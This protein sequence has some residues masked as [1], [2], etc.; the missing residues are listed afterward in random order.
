MYGYEDI[1]GVTSVMPNGPLFADE[2]ESIYT[3]DLMAFHP[4]YIP[5]DRMGTVP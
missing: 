1:S 5:D 2:C 4:S 3:N